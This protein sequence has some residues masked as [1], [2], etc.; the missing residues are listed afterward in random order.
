MVSNEPPEAGSSES[1]FE[2]GGRSRRA[3]E[4]IADKWAVL[5]LYTL[6]RGTMRHNRLHREIEGISQKMLTKTLRRLERDGLVGREAYPVIPPGVE[7]S[8]TPL[9][10]TPIRI[11]AELC[12]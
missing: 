2:L 6:S 1:V 3:L 4:L 7:Y 11:L 8:L 10:E 9:G 5:I 12:R